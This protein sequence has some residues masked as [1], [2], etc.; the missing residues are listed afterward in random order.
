MYPGLLYIVHACTIRR[1]LIDTTG[2]R[3]GSRSLRLIKQNEAKWN[4]NYLLGYQ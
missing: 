2:L 3:G 1:M 4:P